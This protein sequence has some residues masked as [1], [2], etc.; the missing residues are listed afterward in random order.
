MPRLRSQQHAWAGGGRE[1]E[2]ASVD[3]PSIHNFV[4]WVSWACGYWILELVDEGFD[5]TPSEYSVEALDE[6]V[7]LSYTSA[8]CACEFL[9]GEVEL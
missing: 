5:Y 2:E 1:L 9:S 8:S 6:L 4:R 7:K 3:V